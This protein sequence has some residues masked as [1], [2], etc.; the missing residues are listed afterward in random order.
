MIIVYSAKLEQSPCEGTVGNA[1]AF[2]VVETGRRQALSC[3]N[4]S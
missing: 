2:G 1:R 3:G 4:Q